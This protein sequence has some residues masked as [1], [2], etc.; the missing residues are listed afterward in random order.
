MFMET[1]KAFSEAPEAIMLTEGEQKPKPLN[2]KDFEHNKG[3]P[4]E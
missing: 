1:H 3:N 4:T 2:K